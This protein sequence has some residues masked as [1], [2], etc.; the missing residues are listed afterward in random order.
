MLYLHSNALPRFVFRTDYMIDV[1]A[2]AGMARYAARLLNETSLV[3]ALDPDDRTPLHWAC[4]RGHAEIVALF[5]Q[6]GAQADAHD[7]RGTTPIHEAALRN[8]AKIVK[9]LLEA[10]VNPMTPKTKENHVGRLKGGERS[11]VGESAVEYACKN[12]YLDTMKVM[13]PYLEPEGAQI[14]LGRACRQRGVEIVEHL[15]RDSIVSPDGKFDGGTPLY[16]ATYARS[17]RCVELLLNAGADPLIKCEYAPDYRIN[18]MP[19]E[20]RTGPKT[21]IQALFAEGANQE[22]QKALKELLRLLIPAGADM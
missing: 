12:G 10:G 17:V 4:R 5:L 8:H 14:A 22:D 1:A 3:N 6:H 2:Y 9:L 16:I 7:C 18:G 15:L 19:R 21:P 11:T 13:T 20:C